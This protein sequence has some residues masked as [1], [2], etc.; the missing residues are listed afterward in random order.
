MSQVN[1]KVQQDPTN[2]FGSFRISPVL[3]EICFCS[4]VSNEILL[5]PQTFPKNPPKGSLYEEV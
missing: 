1:I 2:M 5:D 4:T 3:M